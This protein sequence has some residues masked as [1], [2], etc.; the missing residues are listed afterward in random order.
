MKQLKI[1]NPRNVSVS[2]ADS[3]KLRI[4]ARAIVIDRDGL[5]ALLHVAR[6]SY[7]KLPGGGMEE[8]EDM[9]TGL[10]RECQEEIGCDIEVIKEIGSTVEYW[11]EDNEK[12]ISHCYMAKVQGQK[13]RPNL[14]ESEKERGFSIIWVPY[15]EAV[16]LF[17]KS[18]PTQF[19]GDYIIPRDLAFLEEAEKLFPF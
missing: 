9:M 11:K 5:V 1:I 4:A 2:E 7:Y 15:K 3:Y 10:K 12:Q 8:G 13:G 6:D 16:D 18:I 19:E 17:K 14:T